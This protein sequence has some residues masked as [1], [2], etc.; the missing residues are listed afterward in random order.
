MKGFCCWKRIWLQVSS[1]WGWWIKNVTREF[2]GAHRYLG[3][4][5]RHLTVLKCQQFFLHLL[6]KKE[7]L[8]ML[9][10]NSWV[11]APHWEE[12]YEQ[13]HWIPTKRLLRQATA[14]APFLELFQEFKE[15]RT[16][17][18]INDIRQMAYDWCP[19]DL[20]PHL[21]RIWHKLFVHNHD[22]FS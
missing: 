9:R 18:Y 7:V 8:S 5:T 15:N 6:N 20:S 11:E 3:C 13:V 16:K 19:F 1:K 2:S 21:L 22:K 10:K 12:D 4:S 17:V 14:V